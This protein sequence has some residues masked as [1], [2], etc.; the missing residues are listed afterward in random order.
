M[1]KKQKYTV[2]LTDEQQARL[3]RIV[4]SKSAKVTHETKVRSKVLLNLDENEKNPLTPT[5]TAKKCKIT[6]ENVYIVRKKFCE[7][8]LE[9][10]IY[11][12]KRETPPVPP[13][14]TGEVEAHI[15]AT[16]CSAPPEGKAHWT[17]QMIGDKIVL[18]GLVDSIGKETVRRTLKKRN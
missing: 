16:A 14:V 10:A 4:E 3:E 8:G 15:I 6:R 17:L 5:A 13:K 1:V 12:K 7:D 9:A 2:R 18:S 11:R